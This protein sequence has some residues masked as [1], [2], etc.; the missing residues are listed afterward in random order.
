[1]RVP[2]QEGDIGF[3]FGIGELFAGAAA[4]DAAAAG[5]AA[6]VTDV[7]ATAG[8]AAAAG[9]VASTAALSA[10][11]ASLIAGASAASAAPLALG[12][13][14]AA[15]AGAAAAGGG[16]GLFSGLTTGTLANVGVGTSL[17]SGAVGALGSVR[18]AEAQKQAAQYQAQVDLNNQKLAGYY[19]NTA[20]AKG[21]ADLSTEQQKQKQQM[22]FIRAS[23]AASGVDV[24]SGSSQDVRNSQEILNNLDALTIMSNTAQQY[25]GYQV[26]GTNSANQAGL[27]QLAASQAGPEAA[28]GA[29][30]SVLSGASGAANQYLAWQRV[31]GGPS[32][33]LFG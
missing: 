9:S 4:T 23:Q 15:A 30:S 21:A 5:T 16:A 18:T 25:Y 20:A 12:T 8:T 11:E 1:M 6:A 33:S 3:D 24:A 32:A 13:A 26:A 31:A 7:A 19:A 10:G 28:I 27:E 14:G 22:D 29:T 2:D 17:A